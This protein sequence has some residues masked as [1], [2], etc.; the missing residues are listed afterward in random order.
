MAPSLAWV[1]LHNEDY[2][3]HAASGPVL[4]DPAEKRS[5]VAAFIVPMKCHP[6]SRLTRKALTGQPPPLWHPQCRRSERRSLSQMEEAKWKCIIDMN[7]AI[8]IVWIQLSL[9]EEI[10]FFFFFEKKKNLTFNFCCMN[11]RAASFTV[12]SILKGQ[13][14]GQS[15]QEDTL[16]RSSLVAPFIFDKALSGQ[17]ATCH[18]CSA[19][20]LLLLKFCQHI[21]YLFFLVIQWWDDN[22]RTVMFTR[23]G[24]SCLGPLC[25]CLYLSGTQV[26]NR[27]KPCHLCHWAA[28][29]PTLSKRIPW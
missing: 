19:C 14:T 12:K 2:S 23:T 13:T 20:L 11:N 28:V 26:Q 5:A 21:S 9:E 17:M 15:P 29:A 6:Q 10:H 25:F 7:I 27:L 4:L 8:L 22:S 24:D 1:N 16:S 3:R 18:I